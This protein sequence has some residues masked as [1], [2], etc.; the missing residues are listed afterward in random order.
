MLDALIVLLPVVALDRTFGGVEEI[1]LR[2]LVVLNAEICQGVLKQH[3]V[4]F[5]T[6]ET[7]VVP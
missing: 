7:A 1:R 4:I 3:A 6:R 2:C 5:G